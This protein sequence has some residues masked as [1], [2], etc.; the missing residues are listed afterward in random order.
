[1]KPKKK[2]F[3]KKTGVLGIL[4]SLLVFAIIISIV[5]LLYKTN[6]LSKLYFSNPLRKVQTNEQVINKTAEEIKVLETSGPKNGESAT[7]RANHLADLYN[8]MGTAYLTKH[9]WDNA[10]AS[11][12]KCLSN[13]KETAAVY[14]SLGL[15]HANRGADI[16]SEQDFTQAEEYY[17]KAAQVDPSMADA[18]YARA[19]LLY[20]HRDRKENAITVA[21]DL[22]KTHASF[23]MG[24]FALGRFYYEEGEPGKALANY[25]DL[26]NVLSK[27]PDSPMIK[28]Y[29]KQC[30]ENINRIM[31]EMAIKKEP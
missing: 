21:E 15:A 31:E 29:R 22:V 10:I 7:A 6:I 19:I 30:R 1:M 12:Q 4:K 16:K 23:Y 11:F 20:Y 28:E 13:G 24:Y 17:L 27:K 26:D 5:F 18:D 3:R 25:Q 2:T 9:M 14:Y 8:R